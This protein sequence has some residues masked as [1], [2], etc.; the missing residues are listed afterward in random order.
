M[1]AAGVPVISV[2]KMIGHTSIQ[3]TQ[4]YVR[5]A[6]RQVEQ[7]YYARI[8]KVIENCEV[9][10][11]FEVVVKADDEEILPLVDVLMQNVIVINVNMPKLNRILFTIQILQ[12]LPEARI[13]LLTMYQKY[14][15]VSDLIKA[16]AKGLLL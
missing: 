10:R 9:K 7:D 6:D 4:L 5:V 2:K 11:G 1:I 15:H 8:Q 14:Q 3:T 12:S 13:L 16:G